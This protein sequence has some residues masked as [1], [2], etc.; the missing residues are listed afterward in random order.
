TFDI[1][2]M[3][4]PF[5]QEHPD[6]ALTRTPVTSKLGSGTDLGEGARRVTSMFDGEEAGSCETAYALPSDSR[7]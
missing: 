4:R 6:A 5:H 3:T 7:K 1:C 2:G